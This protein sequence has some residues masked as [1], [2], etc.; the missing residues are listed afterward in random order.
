MT[1]APPDHTRLRP[2]QKAAPQCESEKGPTKSRKNFGAQNSRDGCPGTK[3]AGVG[4]RSRPIRSEPSPDRR[5]LRRTGGSSGR[6][7]WDRP[8]W[9]LQGAG[10][11]RG[12]G[13]QGALPKS[14]TPAPRLGNRR[15]PGPVGPRRMGGAAEWQSHRRTT[16]RCECFP[17]MIHAATQDVWLRELQTPESRLTWSK[18]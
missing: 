18:H 17:S 1:S 4:S 3:V 14:R 10:Q 7:R 9:L 15:S 6:F 13:T 2:R 5:S 12:E 16:Q 11:T 8:G